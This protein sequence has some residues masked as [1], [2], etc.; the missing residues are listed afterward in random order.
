MGPLVITLCESSLIEFHGSN[1][2]ADNTCTLAYAIYSALYLSQGNVTF[3][4]NT[5]FLQNK[6]RYGGAIYAKN[7]LINFQGNVVF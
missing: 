2:F 5:T 4:G 6:C 7:A 3:Y 1:T